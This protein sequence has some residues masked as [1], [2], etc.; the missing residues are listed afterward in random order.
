ME[1][2]SLWYHDFRPRKL[3][4]YLGNESLKEKAEKWIEE[5]NI[6]HLLLYGPAGTGKTS[7][8]KLLIEN[9]NC[10]YLYLNASDENGID[11]IR[12][13]VK[14]FASTSTFNPLKI[15]ILDEADFLT[16]PAQ[17]ALRNI[18]D[19]FSKETRFIL[20]GNHVERI[21]APLYSRCDPHMV[22][23]PSK[24]EVA[25]HIVVKILDE[26]K[27]KF[28]I[29]DVVEIIN[30]NYPDIRSIIKCLQSNVKDKKLIYN[31]KNINYH[32]DILNILKSPNTKSWKEIRQI[33]AD[34]NVKDF[35]PLMRFL[36]DNMEE[37]SKDSSLA[38]ITILLDEYMW[39]SSSMPD[40]EI[41][42]MA[43]MS[44]IL[45]TI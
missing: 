37:Y 21:S 35:L 12:E 38:Q 5:K 25:E 3:E 11:T 10:D 43:L 23:P 8:A 29:Q 41:N 32:N 2:S 17:M 44:G 27:I 36:Y 26:M 22:V 33:V 24:P 13:K 15:I 4:N 45:K 31:R 18:I 14:K 42:V 19:T 7:L 28:D 20:T 30:D 6:P 40:K 34:N 16:N 39:R 9:I 1:N